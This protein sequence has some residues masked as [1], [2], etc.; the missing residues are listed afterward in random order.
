[1][2]AT[3]IVTTNAA[4]LPLIVENG[5]PILVYGFVFT[6]FNFFTVN[7]WPVREATTNE[8]VFTT[9]T[10]RNLSIAVDM[11]GVWEADKGV[12]LTVLTP[13]FGSATIMYDRTG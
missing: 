3:R 8:I 12:I 7:W 9:S 2:A 4:D 5:D 1:M 10:F 13:S 11:G 6:D